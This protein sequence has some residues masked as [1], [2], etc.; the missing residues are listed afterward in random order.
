M[1]QKRRTT[2]TGA[3]ATAVAPSGVPD[4]PV[5]NWLAQLS[6]GQSIAF[7]MTNSDLLDALDRIWFQLESGTI[8]VV[9]SIVLIGVQGKA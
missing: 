6:N 9:S 1:A 2:S 8:L 3:A 7:Q 4:E 5:L